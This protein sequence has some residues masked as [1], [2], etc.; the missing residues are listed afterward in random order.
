MPMTPAKTPETPAAARRPRWRWPVLA[1]L[2]LVYAL[3]FGELF[4]RLLAPQALVPRYVTAGPDGVR[5]NMANT[6]FRQWTPEVDVTIHYNAAGQRDDRPPPGPR[7]AGDCR[8][9]L[10]GDSF[11]VGFESS[12]A[13]SF[14]ARLEQALAARGHSCRVV[15]FAVS[16][17]GHAENLVILESRVRRYHPDLLLM[18]VHQTDGNDNVRS[19]LYR[20]GPQGPVRSGAT[21]LPGIAI[22]D[23]LNRSASYRWAQENS[24]LYSAV[25][26]W[27]GTMGKRLLATIRLKAAES[28]NEDIALDKTVGGT[29]P[30]WVGDRVLNAQIVE[31]IDREGKAMEAPLML[32]EIPTSGSRSQYVGVMDRILPPQLLAHIPHASPLARFEQMA[33]P[34][35]QLYLERGHRHWTALGNRVAADVAADAIIAQNL[36]P[37]PPTAARHGVNIATHP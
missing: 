21:F 32:F 16:G 27:A 1:L 10:L 26:E 8:I 35:T 19:G 9:A 5:A 34:Q 14:A 12:Y 23:R 22:S 37:P 20:A 25:R 24:H 29:L 3:V 7:T 15:N 28:D 30:A 33:S 36:L 6:S 2:A 13:N 31:A 11:F 4:L 17:F 18:S